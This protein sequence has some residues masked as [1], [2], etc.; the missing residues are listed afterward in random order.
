MNWLILALDYWMVYEHYN[1]Q[2]PNNTINM[3]W[4]VARVKRIMLGLLFSNTP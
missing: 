1:H 4:L 3:R 2:K